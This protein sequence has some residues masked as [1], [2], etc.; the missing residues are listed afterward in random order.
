MSSTVFLMGTAN[1]SNS[2]DGHC[3]E[4]DSRDLEA[5]IST[6]GRQVRSCRVEINGSDSALVALTDHDVFLIVKVPYLPGAVITGLWLRFT[7]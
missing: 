1:I 3:P 5:L 4:Y 7:S 2:G 6:T